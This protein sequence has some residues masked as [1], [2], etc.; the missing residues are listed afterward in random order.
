MWLNITILSDGVPYYRASCKILNLRHGLYSLEIR[1]LMERMIQKDRTK[2]F[3]N[4]IPCIKDECGE[5]HAETLLKSINETLI[6]SRVKAEEFIEK[7]LP[8]IE[9]MNM[10]KFT[11]RY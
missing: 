6:N 1:K 5:E 8:I 7:T 10:I 4:Y 3:D 11:R 9:V 2:L